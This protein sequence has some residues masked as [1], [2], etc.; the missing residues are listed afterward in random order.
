MPPLLFSIWGKAEAL[1]PTEMRCSCLR[2]GQGE[3]LTPHR[4]AR[5]PPT[6]LSRKAKQ[7]WSHLLLGDTGVPVFVDIN[8]RP[9]DYERKQ[10]LTYH[11]VQLGSTGKIC[12]VRQVFL[13][14]CL[15]CPAIQQALP[16][17]E[18]APKG[19]FKTVEDRFVVP[20][21][22]HSSERWGRL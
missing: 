20:E 13:G 16:V 17:L 19:L 1:C 6:E 21:D 4:T 22:P 14:P 3:S 8:C 15:L 9:E 18:M 2:P 11:T 12:G 5:L 7:C 10:Q